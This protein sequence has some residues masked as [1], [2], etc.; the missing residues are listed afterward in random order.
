[1]HLQ[2]WLRNCTQDSYEQQVKHG[3]VSLADLLGKADSRK[4]DSEEDLPRG[5]K[6]E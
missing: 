1:M 5:E 4:E 3:C 6:N 2:Q